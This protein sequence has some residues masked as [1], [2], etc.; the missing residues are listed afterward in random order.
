[1]DTEIFDISDALTE[2]ERPTIIKTV[3]VTTVD[4]VETETVT[5]R[6]QN[7]VVQVANKEQL[8]KDTIDWSKEYLLIHSKESLSMGEL[9]EF[10]GKDYRVFSR[11]LWD[12]YGYIEVIAEE[13]KEPIK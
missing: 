6:T 12:G 5:A 10:N 13:T 11:G 9:I 8:N 1:M 7:C 2:W 3:T 4:F